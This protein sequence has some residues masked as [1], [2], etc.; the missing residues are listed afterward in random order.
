MSVFQFLR[1]LWAHRW[2]TVATGVATVIGAFIA[3][4]IVPPSY[5]SHSRVMLNTMKP[6]PVT[7]E[8]LPTASSRTYVA[9]QIDE[10][11]LS[12][13]AYLIEQ[14]EIAGAIHGHKKEMDE[15]IKS[16]KNDTPW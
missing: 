4:L 6:D 8:I 15:L 16:F 7:G 14:E 11:A 5:E 10:K 13:K 2:I 1:I 9:T 12:D 3:I